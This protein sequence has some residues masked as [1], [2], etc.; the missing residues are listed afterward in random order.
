MEENAFKRVVCF[1]AGRVAGPLVAFLV[2]KMEIELVIASEINDQVQLLVTKAHQINPKAQVSGRVVDV[3]HSEN[4]SEVE[5]LCN[6]ADCVVALVPEPA[7]VK[8]ASLCITHRTPL[9]TASYVSPGMK[10]LADAATEANIPIL[11]EMGLD[12]GMVRYYLCLCGSELFFTRV[13]DAD[14]TSV[15]LFHRII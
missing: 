6:F 9:V 14:R 3:M 11:C 10:A 2:R 13:V 4:A 7:Q 1:G 5:E 12:P 15:V 8:I